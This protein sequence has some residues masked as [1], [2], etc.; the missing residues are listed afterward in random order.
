MRK[1]ILAATLL[2]LS[3]CVSQRMTLPS[4]SAGEQLLISQASDAA[5]LT[6]HLRLPDGKTAFIK[7]VNFDGGDAQYCLS[8]IRQS[9]MQQG[10]HIIEDKEKA[11]LVIEVRVGAI[12]ID[13]VTHQIGVPSLRLAEI[14]IP[15]Y[16]FDSTKHTGVTKFSFFVYDRQ[17]GA[18]VAVAANVTGLSQINK[19][20][21]EMGVISWVGAGVPAKK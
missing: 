5:A 16:S 8:A 20:H 7:A 18:L 13:S 19:K 4:R 12:S 3:G 1:L 6:M 11:D 17:T 2:T 10:N 15:T 21:A 9:L 14:L